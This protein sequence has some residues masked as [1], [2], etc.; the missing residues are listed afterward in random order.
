MAS[1]RDRQFDWLFR[2]LF[3]SDSTQER[4]GSRFVLPRLALAGG[5]RKTTD[6]AGAAYFSVFG[7]IANRR[8]SFLARDGFYA[9]MKRRVLVL[10]RYIPFSIRI[11]TFP[12]RIFR[13]YSLCCKSLQK[14]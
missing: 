7:E 10:V 5:R 4:S 3:N 6:A 12:I 8:L 14:N 11:I 13:D 1:V 2:V 9:K